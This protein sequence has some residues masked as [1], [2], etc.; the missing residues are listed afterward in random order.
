MKRPQYNERSN[1][2]EENKIWFCLCY[3]RAQMVGVKVS[4]VSPKAQTTRTRVLG[5]TIHEYQDQKAQIAF[6]DTPGIFKAQKRRLDKA[7][8][9]AAWEGVVDSDAILY[10]VDTSLK[11][12]LHWNEDILQ[13]L[14]S[15]QLGK[16]K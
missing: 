10:I 6:I 9:A 7:I 13:G 1:K 4:I 5:I 14:K 2:R 16:K 8:V 12:P 11:S 3:W 15:Q